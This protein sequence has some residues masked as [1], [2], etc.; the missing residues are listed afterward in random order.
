MAKIKKRSLG[1][2]PIVGSADF[3]VPWY[4]AI[5]GLV[6]NW[7][8][9][10]SVFM[11]ML[12]ALIASGDHSAAIIWYSHRTTRARLELVKRLCREQVKDE[13]LLQDIQ[14][15]I[16]QF[17]GF[18]RVR[19]FYCHAMYGYDSDLRLSSASGATM[20]QDGDAIMFENRHFDAATMNEIGN[21]ITE[22]VAFNRELWK[23]VDRLQ[24]ALG[25][26]RVSLPRLPP[27]L[28]E[29]QDDLTHPETDGTPEGR[30]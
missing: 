22:L 27:L 21:T 10:E 11:A 13:A 29:N 17:G 2:V 26:Q 23:L 18:S 16:S 24:T 1:S 7:S 12:Q 3:N 14:K 5:G 25:V 9:N 20:P 8:N 4:I 15:A 19:S 30:Q 28:T 6:V